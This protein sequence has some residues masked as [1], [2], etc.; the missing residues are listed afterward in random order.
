MVS[1]LLGDWV[2]ILTD[3]ECMEVLR[4]ATVGRIAITRSALPEIFPVSHRVL[5]GKVLFYSN[6]G[7]KLNSALDRNVVAFETDV[8]DDEQGLARSVL[9]VG[10]AEVVHDE[11][12]IERAGRL[13]F[14]WWVDPH[15]EHLVQVS[16][17]RI[18]GRR[19]R[20]PPAGR[21]S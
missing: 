1:S 19:F 20:R 14:D 18:S 4:L 3:E 6:P 15:P 13:A 16:V 8:I 7:A 17:A 11:D 21:G 5:D 2:E 10:V 9:V 12:L